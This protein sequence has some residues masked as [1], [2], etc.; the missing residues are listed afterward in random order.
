MSD[1]GN[2]P[3]GYCAL[4]YKARGDDSV[5]SDP[6]KVIS[7]IN[8]SAEGELTIRVRPDWRNT[9]RAED[10]AVLQALFDDL[11]ERASLD[12]EVLL[13]QLSSLGVGALQTYHVGQTL[14]DRPDLLQLFEGFEK[15]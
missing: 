10:H 2:F 14:A 11:R 13:K 3:I 12:P 9:A 15:I 5:S 4:E 8:R 6:H 7:I 1:R